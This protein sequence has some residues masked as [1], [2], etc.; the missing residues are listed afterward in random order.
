MFTNPMFTTPMF[1]NPMF[2]T[3][4]LNPSAAVSALGGNQKAVAKMFLR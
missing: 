4:L 1:T 2:T 3:P